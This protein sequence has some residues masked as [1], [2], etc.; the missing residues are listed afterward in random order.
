MSE[1]NKKKIAFVFPGQGSQAVGM[2]QDIANSESSAM[3]VFNT[4]ESEC[5]FELVKIAWSGPE[6]VLRKTIYAQAALF[7]ISAACLQAFRNYSSIEPVCVAGHSLGEISAL[8]ASGVFGLKE[9]ARLTA[10]RGEFMNNA[11]EGSMAAVL[12]AN[13][14]ELKNICSE[15]NIV[16]ANYNTPQQHVISGSKERIEKVCIILKEKKMKA[17][18][19]QVSGAFHSPLVKDSNERFKHELD[20]IK[21]KDSWYPVIQNVDAKAHSNADELKANLKEQMT[22]SVLWTKSVETMLSMGAENFIEFGSGKVL[23]GL[24]KKIDKAVSV[25]SVSDSESLKATLAELSS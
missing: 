7:A 6:E 16:V 14:E 8:W 21:F 13:E 12:G 15:N 11:P 20:S 5:D 19:L 24:I 23:G 18:P 10:R 2:G 3:S 25:M 9:G 1:I 22:S 4:V 17:I